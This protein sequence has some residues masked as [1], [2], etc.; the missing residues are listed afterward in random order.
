MYKIKNEKLKSYK[1]HKWTDSQ[2][3]KFWIYENN[4]PENFWGYNFGLSLIKMFKEQIK[5]SNYILDY[6]CGDGSIVKHILKYTNKYQKVYGF[7]Y[8]TKTITHNSKLVNFYI[9]KKNAQI[10]KSSNIANLE[11]KLLYWEI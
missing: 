8:D 2:I 6:G 3:T 7:E 9:S 5:K 1:F 4:F 11:I 10:L